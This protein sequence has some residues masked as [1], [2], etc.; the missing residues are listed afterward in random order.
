MHGLR[1][2]LLFYIIM[3]GFSSCNVCPAGSASSSSLTSCEYPSKT[4]SDFF[5]DR[6]CLYERGFNDEVQKIVPFFY[7][8]LSVAMQIMCIINFIGI[9]F[10]NMLGGVP[11]PF[12]SKGLEGS[13]ESPWRSA[14]A[15]WVIWEFITL[16]QFAFAFL[17]FI[18]SCQAYTAI[19]VSFSDCLKVVTKSKLPV[20]GVF[21]TMTFQ[22]QPIFLY[23]FLNLTL[24]LWQAL[25]GWVVY[26][27]MFAERQQAIAAGD[28]SSSYAFACFVASVMIGRGAFVLLVLWTIL[29]WLFSASFIWSFFLF[30]P[31]VIIVLVTVVIGFVLAVLAIDFVL[32]FMKANEGDTPGTAQDSFRYQLKFLR[33]VLWNTY[34]DLVATLYLKDEGEDDTVVVSREVVSGNTQ[35]LQE[36][37]SFL[38]IYLVLALFIIMGI[39]FSIIL[40]SG[41]FDFARGLQIMYHFMF[42]DMKRFEFPRLSISLNPAPLSKFSR[43]TP[44]WAAGKLTGRSL[45]LFKVSRAFIGVVNCLTLLKRVLQIAKKGIQPRIQLPEDTPFF[46]DFYDPQRKSAAAFFEVENKM[47]KERPD[48]FNLNV[49]TDRT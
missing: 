41:S 25:Y 38:L 44:K 1:R 21:S 14:L 5:F 36:N 28:N 19:H 7:G 12:C 10:L 34:A 26:A 3:L 31:I 11:T 29:C 46:V 33:T 22:L 23:P 24:F 47:R 45:R 48:G 18:A 20:L 6:Y 43:I 42:R 30:L 15:C 2:R 17:A 40:Y 27:E 32:Y 13:R 9:V 39:Q 4:I 35:G 49:Q 37:I 16:L 8:Q